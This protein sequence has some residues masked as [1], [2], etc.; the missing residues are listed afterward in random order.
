MI[1]CLLYNGFLK[2]VHNIHMETTKL[3]VT[4][5]K[6]KAFARHLRPLN[7]EGRLSCQTRCI[8][9]L[10]FSTLPIDKR[11]ILSL[12]AYSEYNQTTEE[13]SV[14]IFFIVYTMK[15]WNLHSKWHISVTANK[16]LIFFV[17]SKVALGYHIERQLGNMNNDFL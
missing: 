12:Q 17:I 1:C 3:P 15:I 5:C 2:H 13:L 8:T 14:K 9:S 16:C 4:D 6:M 10:D 11:R 7:W